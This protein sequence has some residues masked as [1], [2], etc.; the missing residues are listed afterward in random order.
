MRF[1]LLFLV[2]QLGCADHFCSADAGA[3]DRPRK[4]SVSLQNVED[5]LIL[6]DRDAIVVSRRFPTATA[7]TRIGSLGDEEHL[8]LLPPL[9]PTDVAPSVTLANGQW[10]FSRM[11]FH[12][13]AASVFFVSGGATVRPT[14]WRVDGHGAVIVWLPIRGVEPRGLLISAGNEQPALRILQVTPSSTKSIA[15]FDWWQTASR[16]TTR[17][18]SR[19]AAAALPDGRYVIA[20]IEGE[21]GET[22]LQM[23]ITGG[24]AASDVSVPCNLADR[25][26]DIAVDPTGRLAIAGLSEKNEVVGVVLDVDHPE[27]A[28]C[29]VVSAPGEVAV[30][31][32]YGTPNVLWAG[33]RFVAAWFR[34]DGVVRAC[35]LTGRRSVPVVVD[36]GAEADLDR[37]LR[38]L[39]QAGPDTVTF[40]WRNRDGDILTREL[41][42]EFTTH[43]LGTE[44][45]RLIC[46]ALAKSG[47]TPAD[48]RAIFAAKLR[49]LTWGARK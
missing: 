30:T 37:P 40:T 21:Y 48:I 22:T 47:Q 28:R 24:A 1:W 23:R 14:Q 41:P 4:V 9:A 13:S 8:A 35:E 19:W 33:D 34:D 42:H 16:M 5:V 49:E 44:L 39:V 36:I 26:I 17:H 7:I 38:Q 46:A 11:G 29:R 32:D 3:A 18:S 6:P 20:A 2:A 12:D 43:V 31:S 45:R 10:W 15:A 27:S 25:P